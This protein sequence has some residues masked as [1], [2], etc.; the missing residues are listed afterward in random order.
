VLDVTR[1][2]TGSA[3]EFSSLVALA[4]A[5]PD[6]ADVEADVLG[7][8]DVFRDPLLRYVCSFGI[9]VREAED[10]VQDTFVALYKHLVAG[11]ARTNL[12]GWLFRVAH[13]LALKQRMRQR[14]DASRR[15]AV[16]EAINTR[17]SGH[18][19][20]GALIS[21]ERD[22][23]V[24]AVIRALPERDRQCL[25]LRAAGLPYRDIAHAL[26]ISLGSVAK[27]IAR[28]VGRLGPVVG[29]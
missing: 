14:I 29:R 20:E 3:I 8:F 2:T 1:Q 18:D 21:Q 10:V 28:A 25:R 26:G 12:P 16:E 5:A 22:K 4:P 17:A 19:P 6:H 15:T 9:G 24:A 13:N 7:F 11:K 27:S 23:T